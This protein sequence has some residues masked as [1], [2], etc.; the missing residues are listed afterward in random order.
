MCPPPATFAP[1]EF[2]CSRGGNQTDHQRR[3]RY[4]ACGHGRW[5]KTR[6]LGM[7]NAVCHVDH[8]LR[9][10]SLCRISGRQNLCRQRL[11][12]HVNRVADKAPL[13]AIKSGG[14]NGHPSNGA[15]GVLAV[16]RCCPLT[17]PSTGSGSGSHRYRRCKGA[18]V[19]ASTRVRPNLHKFAVTGD[20]YLVLLRCCRLRGFRRR[21][22]CA[23]RCGGRGWSE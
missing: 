7:H 3:S 18:A 4:T 14:V 5:N 22:G 23:G 17:D 10:R 2:A 19:S 6:R 13:R 9:T 15:A 8:R 12:P 16:G 11:C 20:M 21:T 1:M